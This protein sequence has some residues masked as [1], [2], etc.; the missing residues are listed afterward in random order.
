MS[1]PQV[2]EI[3]IH[4]PREKLIAHIESLLECAKSGELTSI[5]AV[6]LWQGGNVDHGYSL[7]NCDNLRTMIGEMEVL[8]HTLID[9]DNGVTYE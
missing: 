8:K 7:N 9:H 4:Q 3:N 6:S 5:I 2:V 1:K